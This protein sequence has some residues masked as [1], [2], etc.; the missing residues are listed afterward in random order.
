MNAHAD[1]TTSLIGSLAKALAEL[2]GVQKNKN[3]PGLKG[4]R[5]ADLSAVIEALEPIKGHGLWYRQQPKRDPDGALIETFYIHESGEE[6]SAGET[7]VPAGKRDP[8]GFGSALTYCRRYALMTAFGLAAEDDD[9]HAA[10]QEMRN[11]RQGRQQGDQREQS[12][13]QSQ[14]KPSG[15]MSDASFSKIAG[16]LQAT[17]TAPAVLIEHYK[18]KDIRSLSKAQF[19]NAVG[20]LEEQLANVARQQTNQQSQ[21]PGGDFDPADV[22]DCPF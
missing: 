16:L 2:E 18:V 5:Y 8:Q 10:T 4:A 21:H 7:F 20:L 9:G 19:E 14:R 22:G 6:L 12:N 1:I 3:N 17:N 15:G 13:Q 11:A